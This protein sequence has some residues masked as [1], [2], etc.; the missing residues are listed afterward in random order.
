MPHLGRF[1][2]DQNFKPSLLKPLHILWNSWVIDCPEELLD[3]LQVPHVFW[4]A[5]VEFLK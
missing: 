4:V 1:L 2:G 3:F 5:F